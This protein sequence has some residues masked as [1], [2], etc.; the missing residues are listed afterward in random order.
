MLYS[1][2]I[3][4]MMSAF[5]AAPPLDG[6]RAQELCVEQRMFVRGLGYLYNCDSY[7]FVRLAGD[8]G[9]LFLETG[10]LWQ[11]RPAY[12]WIGAAAAVP[13]QLLNRLFERI[14]TSRLFAR[15]WY[16]SPINPYYAGFVFFNLVVLVVA[17]A[18]FIRLSAAR[19]SVAHAILPLSVLGMNGITKGFFWTPHL[20]ILNVLIPVLAVAASSRILTLPAGKR[21]EYLAAVGLLSGCASLIYGS[22]VLVP[23]AATVALL[24][25]DQRPTGFS[26]IGSAVAALMLFALPLVVWR[27]IVVAEAGDFYMHETVAYRQFVWIIDATR[28]GGGALA[29]ALLTNLSLFART[30]LIAL[31]IPVASVLVVKGLAQRVAPPSSRKDMIL[32]RAV[33]SFYVAAVPFFAL[34][35]YYAPRLSWQLVPPLLL[36]LSIDIRR[37]L[38]SIS[39]ARRKVAIR[40]LI[41]IS[42]AYI[43]LIVITDQT[44]YLGGL[45]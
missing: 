34:V 45:R 29:S 2:I 17:A 9:G 27:V 30:L 24:V 31:A 10:K 14:A 37:I 6:R 13:F 32:Q 28:S 41:A 18:L 42:A 36:L 44:A 38:S 11:S 20:Q 21:R 39:S 35:G 3:A 16:Q 4:S 12:V 33:L 22:F 19:D 26:G 23:V 25:A 43:I 7:E 1:I 15:D 40:G 5:L 8:P